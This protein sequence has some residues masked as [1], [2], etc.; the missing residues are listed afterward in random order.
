MAEKTKWALVPQSLYDFLSGK[1]IIVLFLALKFPRI[2]TGK[3]PSSKP[4]IDI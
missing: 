3:I 4:L 1:A 2:S